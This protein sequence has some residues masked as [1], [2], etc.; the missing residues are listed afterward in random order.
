MGQL[1]LTTVINMRA[2]GRTTK[3]RGL[4]STIQTKIHQLTRDS[5][6]TGKSQARENLSLMCQGSSLIRGSSQKTR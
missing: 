1:F 4:E 6:R 5:S 3:Y 2:T